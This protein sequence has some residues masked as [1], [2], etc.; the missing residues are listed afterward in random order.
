[1]SVP[2]PGVP[3]MSRKTTQELSPISSLGQ[4][5][6]RRLQQIERII[7]E[8]RGRRIREGSQRRA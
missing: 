8:S 2:Q 6:E 7:S 1:M 5:N 4:G 3:K